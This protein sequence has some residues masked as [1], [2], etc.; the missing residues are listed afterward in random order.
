M[1]VLKDFGGFEI[2]MYFH[3]EN[4][5]HVHVECANCTAKVSIRGAAVFQGQIDKKFRKRAL[6]WIAE[7]RTFLETK[8][9]EFKK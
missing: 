8:W 4:P 1:P 3:D 9:E 5:P 7:N 6:E 2:S